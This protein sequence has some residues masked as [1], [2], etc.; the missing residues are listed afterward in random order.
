MKVTGL[1]VEIRRAEPN[2]TPACDAIQ[3]LPQTGGVRVTVET[4]EGASGAGD[5]GFGRIVGAPDALAALIEH[6][7]KPLVIGTDPACVGART[8]TSQPR[9][10]RA[11]PISLV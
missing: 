8:S 4:D 5:V 9:S 3:A 7:L 10:C 6:E 1:S 2:P 11:R